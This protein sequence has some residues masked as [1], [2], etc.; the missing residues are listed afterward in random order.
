MTLARQTRPTVEHLWTCKYVDIDRSIFA[1]VI[2]SNTVMKKQ[3][4]LTK[5]HGP[6]T[7]QLVFDTL[8]DVPPEE[9]F[10]SPARY[11]K[12]STYIHHVAR[13]PRR[14]RLLKGSCPFKHTGHIRDARRIPTTYISIE[15][16]T[17]FERVR[18]VGDQHS[19]PCRHDVI[20]GIYAIYRTISVHMF[21]QTAGDRLRKFVLWYGAL[22]KC[23]G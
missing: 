8:F 11:I 10:I 7:D 14:N 22:S 3:T 13:V 16:C 15:L 5:R 23:T 12:H 19:V 1:V 18:H 6:I 17:A 2:V 9:V 21:C 20:V 4:Y